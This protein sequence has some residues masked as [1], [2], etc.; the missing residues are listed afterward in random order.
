MLLLDHGNAQGDAALAQALGKR[1]AVIASAAVFSDAT[2]SIEDSGK[3]PLARLPR[4][5]KFLLP[6]KIFADQAE[7]GVVNLTTDRSGTPRGVPLLFRTGDNIE[8]SFS[9]RVAALATGSEPT[10]GVNGL[11]MAGRHT[12]TDID[13]VLPLAFYGRHGTI[14][15]RQ[16]SRI[17]E[18]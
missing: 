2:Q 5:E 16:R 3:G 10:I 9:L 1:P 12:P 6:L 11:T 13:H 17:V 15:D 8:M 4:A 14:P 18:Q 7:V